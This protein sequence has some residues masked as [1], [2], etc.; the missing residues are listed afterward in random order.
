MSFNKHELDRRAFMKRLISGVGV[1]SVSPMDMLLGN[2]AVQFLQKGIAHAAGEDSAFGD[3]KYI[4]VMLSGGVPSF[5]WDN[6]I[7]PNGNDNFTANPFVG[8]K[9]VNGQP[10][11]DTTKIGD[12]HFSSFWNTNIPTANGGVVSMKE[13]ARHILCMRGINLQ[14]D[15]HV[16]DSIKQVTPVQGL[17][18]LSGLTADQATTPIPSTGNGG[19]G[20]YFRSGRGIMHVVQDGSNPFHKVLSPFMQVAG[21]NMQTTNGGAFEKAID[22]L[23]LRMNAYAGD[24]HKFLPGSYAARHNAKLLMKKSFGNLQTIY[25]DLLAKYRSLILR[26]LVSSGNLALSGLDNVIIPG[27]STRGF[28]W[29]RDNYYTGNNLMDSLN[30]A[31]GIAGMAEGMAIAEFMITEG[32]SS[33]AFI[34]VGRLQGITFSALTDASGA[35][36]TNFAASFAMDDGHFTGSHISMLLYTRYYKALSA[37]LHELIQQLKSVSTYKG[38]LFDQT[39]LGVTTDFNRSPMSDGN[40]SDHGWNGSHYTIFSGMIDGPIVRG[41]IRV[42]GDG[43][44]GGTWGVAAGVPE[45]QGRQA[46]IGN[47]AS[48]VC[49]L[50]GVKSPTPND[51]PFATVD[52]ATG[53]VVTPIKSVNNV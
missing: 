49:A 3:M 35:V 34:D 16:L 19:G 52:P 41:N 37:C 20:N 17:P 22:E 14:V 9:F 18:S 15:D 40:H 25:S 33:S 7:R 12:F 29:N 53:K 24:K 28:K 5:L 50:L 47:A 8:S 38:N 23:L 13:L 44:Y 36:R 10:V 21:L 1:M 43:Q 26:A 48:T 30:N 46:L 31:T 42:A 27:G 45:L 51:A 11:Y 4:N 2:M 32:Y 6:P 39:V